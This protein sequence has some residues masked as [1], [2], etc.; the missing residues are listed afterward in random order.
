[1]SWSTP[2]RATSVPALPVLYLYSGFSSTRYLWATEGR[3]AQILDNF[4]AQV[5]AVPMIV[6]VPDPHGLPFETTPMTKPALPL[7]F[8]GPAPY[9]EN[10]RHYVMHSVDEMVSI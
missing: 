5:K 1:M 4:L 6:V 10:E 3:L 7:R 9:N 2:R 8:P